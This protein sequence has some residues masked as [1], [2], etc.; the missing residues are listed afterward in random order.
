[1]TDRKREMDTR[2]NWCVYVLSVPCVSVSVCWSGVYTDCV[3]PARGRRGQTK[4]VRVD[5]FGSLDKKKKQ[6][7]KNEQK[8]PA[9]HGRE[10]P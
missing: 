8:I 6:N 2:A 1:M 3:L 7:R 10:H 5:D 4:T 9:R